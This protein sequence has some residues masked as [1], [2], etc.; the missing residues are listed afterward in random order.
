MRLTTNGPISFDTSPSS[1]IDDWT[2]RPMVLRD[3]S[4][5]Q[6]KLALTLVSR[7]FWQLASEFLFETLHIDSLRSAMNI[8]DVLER[9]YSPDNSGLGRWT[10]DIYVYPT[11]TGRGHLGEMHRAVIRLLAHCQNLRGVSLEHAWFYPAVWEAHQPAVL[12]AIP[13]GINCLDWS[14][15]GSLRNKQELKDAFTLLLTRLAPSLRILCLST[16]IRNLGTPFLSLSFPHLSYLAV[17]EHMRNDMYFTSSWKLPALTHLRLDCFRANHS[18]D[19]FFDTARPALLSL[20]IGA[21]TDISVPLTQ[22]F[23]SSCPDLR[24]LAYPFS[25]PCIGMWAANTHRLLA[26]ITVNLY[27]AATEEMTIDDLW[28]DIPSHILPLSGLAFPSLKSLTFCNLE[29]L[30]NIGVSVHDMKERISDM[31]SGLRTS[32]IEVIFSD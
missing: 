11:D 26:H 1:R 7:Q 29:N 14:G 23:L 21:Q 9:H 32:G 2:T 15:S 22:K 24:N 6:T 8:A 18:I 27:H 4:T 5:T 10:K 28:A 31:T 30:H 17:R 20:E 12:Q 16:S 19:A 25:R 3:R 13:S